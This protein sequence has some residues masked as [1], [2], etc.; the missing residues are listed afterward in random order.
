MSKPKFYALIIG[1]EILNRRREDSHF[2]FVSKAL[3]KYGYRLSGSFII[4]DD[5]KLI[6]K[7]VE[8]IASLPNSIL[9]SFGGIGSTPDDYTR[10]ASAIA[11]RD[12]NLY[13][14]QEALE[15]IKRER[16]EKAYPHAVKMAELP[17]GAK[18]LDNPVNKMP[19]FYLEDRFFFMP[20]F[21]QMSHPMV[22]KI[23]EDILRDKSKK[24]YRYT[25]T[26]LTRESTLIDVMKKIPEGVELSSLPKIYS[27]G[28]RVTISVSSE[29]DNLAKEAF[30]MFINELE[31]KNI[32]YSIGEK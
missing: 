3:A 32:P 19:A 27:D 10:E 4:E 7:S 6:V 16:G 15:I 25:L 9:F 20:G 1:T 8:F 13:T 30:G 29:N 23:L 14:H 17:A 5:P 2:E 22:E 18:L 28:V 26:A 24:E 12:G 21:P 11:L 31:N